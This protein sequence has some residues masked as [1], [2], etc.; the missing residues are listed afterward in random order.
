MASQNDVAP[1]WGKCNNEMGPLQWQVKNEI[2]TLQKQVENTSTVV[3]T[4]K[5]EAT[6]P[7]RHPESNPSV[8]LTSNRSH[9]NVIKRFLNEID[10]R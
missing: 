7:Y 2:T 4:G 6:D 8:N 9:L 10:L 5:C 1:L 3:N